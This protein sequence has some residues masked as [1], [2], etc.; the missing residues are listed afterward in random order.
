LRPRNTLPLFELAIAAG[1]DSDRIWIVTNKD[2]VWLSFTIAIST[3]A[4]MPRK[5]SEQRETIS[6]I[7]KRF[8][9]RGVGRWSLFTS[10]IR[11]NQRGA[12]LWQFALENDQL[13]GALLELN[14]SHETRPVF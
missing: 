8:R 5:R 9:N 3:A 6:A 1:V 14:A 2:G 11:A 13:E 10:K 12:Q 7:E 4:R